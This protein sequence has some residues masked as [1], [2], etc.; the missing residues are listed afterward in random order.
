MEL[1]ANLSPPAAALSPVFTDM[2]E[3]AN[4]G[5]QDLQPLNDVNKGQLKSGHELDNNYHNMSTFDNRFDKRFSR[6]S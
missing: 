5:R 4:D 3:L 6:F 1:A 2:N